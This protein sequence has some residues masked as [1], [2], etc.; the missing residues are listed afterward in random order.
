MT[1]H[2]HGLVDGDH[3]MTFG[4]ERI[5]DSSGPRAEVQDRA[6]RMKHRTYAGQVRLRRE[7]K[8]HL[9]R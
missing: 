7:R 9:D 6:V 1:T 4:R 2:L 3:F 8:V 5:R